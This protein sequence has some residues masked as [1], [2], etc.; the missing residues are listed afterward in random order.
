M[1]GLLFLAVG[2]FWLWLSWFLASRMPTWLGISTPAWRWVLTSVVLVLLLVGPFLDHIVGMRQFQRLCDE[3]T[4]LQILPSA[5]NTRNAKE[6]SAQSLPLKG[7]VITIK[8]QARKIIDSDTGAEIAHYNYFSTRGGRVGSLFM[9][10]GE[11]A[12]AASKKGHADRAKY[13][14]FAEKTNLTYEEE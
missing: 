3:Q 2:L 14:Q 12:C 11:Y 1:I 5:A 10:G 7:Y 8:Q 6:L 9:M 4:G 13:T